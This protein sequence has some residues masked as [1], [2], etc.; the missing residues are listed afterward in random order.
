MRNLILLA[1]GAAL[2]V[3]AIGLCQ[4][5]PGGPPAQPRAGKVLV[6]DHEGT[7]TGDIERDGAFYRV[8]RLTG[9]VSVPASR[10]LTLCGS[11]DEAYQFL[12]GRAA[13]IDPDERLRL[14]EWC[15]QHGLR[16]QALAEYEAASR[17]RPDDT[18]L[19]EVVRRLREALK[20]PATAGASLP[21]ERTAPRVD[22]TEETKVA[23]AVKV[24]PI[25]MNACASCH[26]DGRSP[27]FRL[28]R[29]WTGGSADRRSLE[30]NLAAAA[31]HIDPRDVS[32]SRLLRKAVTVHA[33]GMTAAPLRGKQL[34]AFRTLEEWARKL[35]ADN[36][37]LTPPP[38]TPLP[39]PSA[40]AQ[41]PTTFPYTPPAPP[42]R[43]TGPAFGEGRPVP[44]A[45]EKPIDDGPGSPDE[46]N[47]E[48]HAGKK[49]GM[50]P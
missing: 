48:N 26:C 28:I 25:L 4:P 30:N 47:R 22:V 18:R 13:L 43:P 42:A 14:A 39:H 11:M 16:E 45:E 38:A 7:M 36:P 1:S 41:V 21:A 44:K 40:V 33:E 15:K 37:G 6:L 5:P 46:F 20:R 31:A 10:V 8:R 35:V 9:E 2:A 29:S 24:Q 23:F 12:R 27:G 3:A 32:A 34:A 19:R 17:L 49:D 50:G